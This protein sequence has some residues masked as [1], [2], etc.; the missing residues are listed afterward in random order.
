MGRG[1]AQ[2]PCGLPPT[3]LRERIKADVPVGALRFLVIVS[4]APEILNLPWELL[5]PPDGEF[6]GINPL[7]RI[8]R[9]PISG[10][11]LA[12]FAGE[13]RPRPLRLLFMACSP[14]DLPELDYE[15]E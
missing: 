12:P 13:L 9:L 10:K 1:H 2:S 11:Q 3:P 7:F 8:R 6:L 14:T 4:E 15:H 5:L